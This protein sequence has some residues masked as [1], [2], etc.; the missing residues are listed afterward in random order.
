MYTQ[1]IVTEL[2]YALRGLKRSRLF[3]ISVVLMLG[4]VIAANS[5]LFTLLYGLVIRQLPFADANRL[6]M[7]WN[8]DRGS[9]GQQHLPLIEGAFAIYQNDLRN[10]ESVAAFVPPIPVL[11]PYTLWGSSERVIPVYCSAELFQLLRV[12]PVVGRWMVPQDNLH[13]ANQVAVISHRFWAKHFDMSDDAIGKSIELN[14]F[15]SRTEF[16]I[17][18]VMPDEFAF[19]YPLLPDR[20]DLWLSLTYVPKFL[21]GYHF[22]TIGRLK[23]G[24]SLGSAQAEVD[25]IT[26]RIQGEYPKYYKDVEVELVPLRTELTRNVQSVLWALAI[27]LGFVLLL[28]CANVANLFLAR[29]AAREH[30]LAI[31]RALGAD[32]STLVVH[33]AV[34]A[35]LLSVGGT[36]VGLLLTYFVLGAFP[37]LLPRGIYIPRVEAL[38]F[39][40][41]VV[42]FAS[43][44]CV[45]AALLIAL[46]ASLRISRINPRELLNASR[47]V[48]RPSW[49]RRPGSALLIGE[50]TM[51]VILLSCAFLM[52]QSIKHFTAVQQPYNPGHLLSLKLEFSNSFPN[53]PP[54]LAALYD[55]FVRSATEISG[56]RSVALADS[57]PLLQF[58]SGFNSP[59]GAGL[60]GRTFAPAEFHVVS[61]TFSQ[62][63]NF[64]V[65][66]GRWLEESDRLDTTPVAVING[67]MRDQYWR[68]TDALGE[69]IIPEMHFGSMFSHFRIVGVVNEARRFGTGEPARPAV[70]VSLNQVPLRNIAVIARTSANAAALSG[71]LEE[72]SSKIAPSAVTVYDLRAGDEIIS[73]LTAKARFTRTQLSLFSLLAAVLGAVGV[74]SLVS[75]YTAQQ[76]REI[77]IRMALGSTPAAAAFFVLR[78]GMSLVGVGTALGLGGAL[79]VGRFLSGLIYGA[80]WTDSAAV[81]GVAAALF[82]GVAFFACYLP[83]RRAARLDPVEVLRER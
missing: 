70:F 35:T 50:V 68:D 33:I 14:E 74:Y 51:A 20:P 60:I 34:E 63:M 32:S 29:S 75:F 78:Q 39:S 4:L 59:G 41:P 37:E 54:R 26:H 7:L 19:P 66:R 9:A 55:D 72:A 49:L 64:S 52:T 71:A 43:V 42:G 65:Q 22:Y 82:N 23:S 25:I 44:A 40:L 3:T 62:M 38:T 57:F 11:P 28:G 56:I 79:W 48:S 27:A 12:R 13:G 1:Q 69:T 18:G 15:G 21:P 61:P 77:G 45:C 24:V 2:K 73:E 53:D 6:V 8:S 36:L 5:A 31:R 16:T 46:P 47:R 10:L 83:A 58:T 67:A 76:V 17:V 80:R 81:I 30:N